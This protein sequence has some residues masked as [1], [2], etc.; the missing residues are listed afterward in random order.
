MKRKIKIQEMGRRITIDKLSIN[1]DENNALI[2]DEN[3]NYIPIVLEEDFT[4]S[5]E[6]K[7]ET[8]FAWEFDEDGGVEHEDKENIWGEIDE[9]VKMLLE[10]AKYTKRKI[11]GWF[12]YTDDRTGGAYSGIVYIVCN[13]ENQSALVHE[14]NVD[15]NSDL[16][17]DNLDVTKPEIRRITI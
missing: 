17:L 11:T 14:F 13:E 16:E 7:Y 10:V 3:D 8:G 1:D 9:H 4:E 15:F 6:K 5:L 12:N 2:Y